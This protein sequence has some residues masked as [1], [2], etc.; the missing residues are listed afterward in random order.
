LSLPQ[1]VANGHEAMADKRTQNV[2]FKMFKLAL[3]AAITLATAGAA[4][5]EPMTAALNTPVAKPTEFI[6]GST[7]WACAEKACVAKT[8]STETGSWLECRKLVQ[9]VGKVTGYVS[10][11]DNKIAMCNAGAKK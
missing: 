5:A 2:E 7:L 1:T 6:A 8:E 3:A 11:D 4:F 9:Q 10:L